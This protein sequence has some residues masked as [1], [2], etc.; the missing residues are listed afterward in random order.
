[1]LFKKHL[2]RHTQSPSAHR[3]RD[4][5]GSAAINFLDATRGK[6]PVAM[7]NK[8]SE[9]SGEVG[10]GGL[11]WGG[12]GRGGKGPIRRFVWLQNSKV[13]S[14]QFKLIIN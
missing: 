4:I 6:M 8:C 14:N 12:A 3:Q 9:L 5:R 10:W 1:M 2:P 13:L 7:S 11:G